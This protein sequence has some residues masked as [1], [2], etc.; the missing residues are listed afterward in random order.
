MNFDAEHVAREGELREVFC[1]LHVREE[2]RFGEGT[3]RRLLFG[4]CCVSPEAS[5]CESYE[6]CGEAEAEAQSDE[7]LDAKARTMTPGP[8]L[9]L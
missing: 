1:I 3:S 2:Q 8:S 5:R 6:E 4:L 7:D 9:E